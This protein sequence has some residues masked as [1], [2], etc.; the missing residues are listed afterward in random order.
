MMK[1]NK[2][3]TLVELL[4]VLVLLSVV[5]AI[6]I[7]SLSA[8]LSRTKDKQNQSN[9]KFLESAAEMYVSDYFDSV[10]SNMGDNNKCKDEEN[11]EYNKC[12][13][14]ITISDLLEE[15][16]IDQNATVD[17]DGNEFYGVIVYDKSNNSYQYT[18]KD[19]SFNSC[20]QRRCFL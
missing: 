2:G 8:S 6:V 10:K 7:P 18:D 19:V 3:F 16:Y 11:G 4:A 14:Y 1:D 5:M 12:K 9:Y 15:G 20:L 17:A 13:C